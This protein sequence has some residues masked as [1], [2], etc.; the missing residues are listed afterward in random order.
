MR[1]KKSI[2]KS[3]KKDN[4]GKAYIRD[5][6]QRASKCCVSVLT[7]WMVLYSLMVNK[8]AATVGGRRG[9][10]SLATVCGAVVEGMG[11]GLAHVSDHDSFRNRETARTKDQ[12]ERGGEG[13]E[14]IG[15][16]V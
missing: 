12:A 7:L 2:D 11:L 14:R 1:K 6:E 13:F 3:E 16:A 10:T 9:T 15:C 4:Q 5:E 8:G